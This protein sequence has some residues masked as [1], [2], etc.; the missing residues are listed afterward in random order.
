[1]F[2]R[3]RHTVLSASDLAAFLACRHRTALDLAV[4]V[5]ARDAPPP[6]RDLLLE[7]LIERGL[8]HEKAYVDELRGEGLTIADLGHVDSRERSD[9]LVRAT[10][11]AMQRGDDVIVQGALA[12]DEWFGKPDILRRVSRPS[13]FGDWSYEV[14]DTKLSRETK[15][16]TLL[17][18]SLY[19]Q[20]LEAAQAQAPEWMHVVTPKPINPVESY[21][22]AEF[23]AY[24][25]SVRS[26]LR[27]AV[28]GSPDQLAQANYPEPVEHCLVCRWS[29]ECRSK[30]R[31]DDHLSL[32]AGASR[33]QR[34]ELEDRGIA[35]L[36]ALAQTS[37]PFSFKPRRGSV[38]SLVNTREQA[39]LQFESRDLEIPKFELRPHGS[40]N[41]GLCRLPE[42]SPGDAFIDLE[43]D[44]FVGDHGREYLFGMVMLEEGDISPSYRA[45]WALREQDERQA[46][47]SVMDLLSER[48][49][50]H[51]GM[52]VYH[53][54]PHEPTAFKRLMGHYSTRGSELDA[55]LR[56][57]RFVD[58]YAVV[59]QALFIGV[60]SYSIKSLEPVF[61]YERSVSLGDANRALRRM[62]L[63]LET[64]DESIATPDIRQVV[65]GYNADDCYSALRLRD[66]LEEIRTQQMQL[67][68]RFPRPA[69]GSVQEDAPLNPHEQRVAELRPR[70]LAGISETEADRTPEQHARWLL[71]YL[72]DYHRREDKASFWEYYRLKELPEDELHDEPQAVVGLEFEC[73][74]AEKLNAKTG[75]PT[76]T[77][78]DRY[79]YPPQEMEIE[80][81]CDLRLQ[82]G[83]TFGM[84]AHVDRAARTLDVVKRREQRERHPTSLFA[85]KHIASP[86]QE[87]SIFGI[88]ERVLADGQ[89]VSRPGR[90][91]RV[92]HAL[93]LGE[94]PSL[95]DRGP[96]EPFVGG[97]V[98]EYLKH[99]VLALDNS[100]LAVQGP[101][102][103]GKTFCGAEM[104]VALVRHGCRVGIAATSHK[105]IRKLLDEVSAA[106]R[107]AGV[108]LALGQKAGEKDAAPDDSVRLFD[109]NGAARRALD[110]GEIMVLG[111]T[112]WLWSHAELRSSVD[113][114]FIDEAGQ[115]SLAN[116]LAMSPAA[117]S[118]VLLGDPQQ[119][120]Q[121]TKAAHPP[122][123]GVS[124]LEHMLGGSKTIPPDRGVFLPY[125]WRMHPSITAFTS[126]LFYEGRL[127]SRPG[128]EAQ[129][130]AGCGELSGSGMRV[131]PVEHEWA[132]TWCEEEIDVVDDLVG[133]L[134]C[135]GATWSD[136]K[137]VARQMRGS[138]IL[139]VAPYNAQVT[140]LTERVADLGARVGTVD[141]FQGQ[142]APVVIYSMTTS[143]A[144]DAPRGMEFLYSLNRLNVAT[145]RARCAVFLVASSKLLEVECRSVRQMRLANALCHCYERSIETTL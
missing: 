89:L 109:S 23:A 132:R 28:A 106:G 53:Y 59:R 102:G 101:P 104:I 22:C 115:M 96:F 8:A 110:A 24:A 3:N 46:F 27:S 55:M 117:K 94:A 18:L 127:R 74:I 113:V 107:R 88:A 121:P 65:E 70:L 120:Q 112:A 122:G 124:V 143:R 131:V 25:R 111:G 103:A 14:A 118:V 51:P 34:K 61:G 36:T 37:L 35:T 17:Q 5:G 92:E 43:S 75:K 15:A 125:T 52:H 80:R 38:E 48:W 137:G 26:R 54:A 123:V 7:V 39:R 76:G 67:G 72:L 144:E 20:M 13:V 6:R 100:V 47:E 19:S 85:F 10:L 86:A 98:A 134:T 126:E 44:L 90:A 119:L 105:V 69:S 81:G 32:V 9:E 84:L 135:K 11:A 63:A 91:D 141:K 49:R 114:L 142:E 57:N 73:R 136:A 66:W 41:L 68:A 71:A 77:V 58:L 29:D 93:L 30:R 99:A 45:I 64:D 1:M 12:E 97:D 31:A 56:S 138:D 108:V 95:G 50:K 133:R 60:E 21:R 145:S 129:C 79:R 78:T 140:R 42:P 128:L 33:S 82:E 16:G 116:A 139:V 83:K 40:D 130:I 2:R 4:A 87:D 62:E